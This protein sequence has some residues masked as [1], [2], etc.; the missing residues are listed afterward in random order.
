MDHPFVSVIIPVYRDW[1]SLNWALEALAGQTYPKER[2]EILVVDNDSADHTLPTLPNTNLRILREDKP[3]SYAARNTGI[4]S[5]KGKILAFCDADCRPCPSWV[6][7]AVRF[8]AAHP[9]CNRLAGKIELS[10]ANEADVSL[11][12]LYETVFAFRQEE[13]ARQ[14]VSATANMFSY[15]HVF[16]DVG[17]FDDTLLSGGDLEWGQRASLAGSLIGYAP[18][19]LVLHQARHSVQALIHKAKRVSSGYIELNHA[20]IAKHPL[21]AA[22]HGLSM[23]KPPIKAGQMIFAR[24]DIQVRKRVALYGLEYMLKLVQFKEYARLQFGGRPTR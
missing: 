12:E 16:E 14:G 15:R 3:G 22:Y 18:E 20:Q 11:A 21:S 2:F 8:F 17:L 23:L 6:E 1:A 10:Y 5:S 24:Q 19:V 4:T 7:Q 9:G 13:Y